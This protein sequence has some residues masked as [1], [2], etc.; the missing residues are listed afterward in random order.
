MSPIVAAVT[1]A[2]MTTLGRWARGKTLTIDTVVG[3][4]GVALGLAVVEQAN[5]RLARQLG[6]LI[7]IGVAAAHLPILLDSTGLTGSGAPGT[8][9]GTRTSPRS[10]TGPGG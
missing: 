10:I 6:A 1:V 5:T 2:A 8:A 4:V 3:V 7:V 9:G